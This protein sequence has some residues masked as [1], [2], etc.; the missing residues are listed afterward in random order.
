[1]RKLASLCRK[2]QRRGHQVCVVS[3]RRGEYVVHWQAGY[4]NQYSI[5]ED[6]SCGF[7]R[8]KG[9]YDFILSLFFVY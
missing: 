9:A 6:H 4:G 1:M 3:S 5:S 7:F 8:V 2:L